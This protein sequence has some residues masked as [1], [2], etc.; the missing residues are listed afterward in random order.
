MDIQ[1]EIL[2]FPTG[3]YEGDYRTHCLEQYK[4][5][6]EMA[7]RISGRRLSAN[8]FF[9]TINSVLV[10]FVTYVH[11][12]SNKGSDFYFLI[13]LSGI[14]LC[15]TWYRL[16]RSY[17]DL[18]LGKFKMI[19]AMEKHLPFSI[20]QT[21]WEYLGKGEDRTKYLPF[22][23][24]EKKI[25]WVFFGLHSVVFLYSFPWSEAIKYILR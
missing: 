19:H 12:L 23:K 20:Y 21:E 11:L 8:S 16:I 4:M 1:K 25:P 10:G 3:E 2:N 17:D 5:Y 22:T 24:I 14:I 7:D 13:G 15:F 6:V 18:N 9:L